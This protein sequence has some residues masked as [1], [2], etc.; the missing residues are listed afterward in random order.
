MVLGT[1]LHE[2]MHSLGFI[3]EHSRPDRD[4]YL[5]VKWS[6]IKKSKIILLY[7]FETQKYSFALMGR[8]FFHSMHQKK[9]DQAPFQKSQF[10]VCEILTFQ[11]DDDVACRWS[12]NHYKR[13]QRLVAC[14]MTLTSL[15]AAVAPRTRKIIKHSLGVFEGGEHLLQN[16]G[17][18]SE[19]LES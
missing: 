8:C 6:N 4:K 17:Q 5:D 7:Y 9:L 2:T 12:Y 18:S 13:R 3:H 19:I 1:V 10:F 11:R 14:S 15:V 16:S